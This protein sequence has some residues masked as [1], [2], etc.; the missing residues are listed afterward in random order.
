MKAAT[1]KP[2]RYASYAAGGGRVLLTSVGTRR[3][4]EG[5]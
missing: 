1:V 3:T 2:G 5:L 4:A